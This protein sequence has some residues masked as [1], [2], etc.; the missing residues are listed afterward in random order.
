MFS[1]IFLDTTKTL[2]IIPLHFLDSEIQN[3]GGRAGTTLAVAVTDTTVYL[4]YIDSNGMVSR[5]TKPLGG[6]DWGS[7]SIVAD[8]VSSIGSDSQLT[9]STADLTK[10]K[11]NHIFYKADQQADKIGFVHVM[12]A[13]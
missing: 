1:P 5:V 2:L 6:G 12:D 7:G 3:A 9:V 4:Y 11:Y 8:A 10:Q 13:Q